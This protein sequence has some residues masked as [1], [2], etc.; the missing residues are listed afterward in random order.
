MLL[1]QYL[2]SISNFNF[3]SYFIIIHSHLNYFD[4]KSFVYFHFSLLFL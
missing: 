2:N 3:N 4:N 1:A